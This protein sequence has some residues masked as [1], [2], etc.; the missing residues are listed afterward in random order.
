MRGKLKEPSTYL[1][2]T[3]ARGLSTDGEVV[4]DGGDN[5]A[6]LIRGFAAIS[7]GEALGH[8]MWIDATFLEQAS[9][10]INAA[11]SARTAS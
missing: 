2:G 6:G 7:R 3:A 4:R 9:A 1:R 11:A 10:A 8:E 5:G